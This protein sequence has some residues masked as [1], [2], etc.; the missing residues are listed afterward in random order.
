MRRVNGANMPETE[1]DLRKWEQEWSDMMVTIWTENIVRLGIVDTGNLMRSLTGRV[2]QSTDQ[3]EMIHEFALYG[4]YVA[5]GTGPAYKWKH[6]T[7]RQGAKEE[8][9]NEGDL[10]FLSQSYRVE[11]GLNK[12]RKTG[13]EWGGR[14]AGGKPLSK[15]RN[16]FLRKYLRSMYVL[17]EMERNVYGEMF[18]GNLSN[19]LDAIMGGGADG[20]IK[21]RNGMDMSHVL[22]NF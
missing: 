3:K 6:W 10:E 14:V 7:K 19:V 17:A 5:R 21:D 1:E 16:W 13:P 12:K 9:V 11:H 4:I 2:V 15:K 8:R 20:S 22:A 18:M